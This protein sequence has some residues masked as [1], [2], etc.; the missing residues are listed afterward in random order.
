M[1]VITYWE[2]GTCYA[3]QEGNFDVE[4][5][6]RNPKEALGDLFVKLDLCT[7]DEVRWVRLRPQDLRDNNKEPSR[8]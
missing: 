5:S 8:K 2:Y 6:G 1:R 4:G 7:V 3:T